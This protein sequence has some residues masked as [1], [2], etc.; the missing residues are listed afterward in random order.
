MSSVI[1]VNQVFCE[2]L[3]T[4]DLIS[5]MNDKLS[6]LEKKLQYSR[7]YEEYQKVELEIEECNK[8]M[9]ELLSCWCQG[10]NLRLVVK[11]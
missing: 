7:T 2:V 1:I 10:D 3:D 6:D 5:K 4:E 8:L 11:S 9:N